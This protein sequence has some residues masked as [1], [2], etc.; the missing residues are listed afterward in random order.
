[1]YNM[2]FYHEY[3][4]FPTPEILPSLHLALILAGFTVIA[5]LK[6]GSLTTNLELN[7]DVRRA[8]V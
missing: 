6:F 2:L 8:T 1:M 4:K 7:A 3:G 5:I